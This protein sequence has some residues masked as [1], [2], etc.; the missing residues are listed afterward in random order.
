MTWL[1][2]SIIATLPVILCTGFSERIS[3]DVS[4]AAGIKAFLLKP[5][6]KSVL[7][8]TLRKVLDEVQ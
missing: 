1:I 7:A 8:R 3:K 5:I 6:S 4:A 2:P